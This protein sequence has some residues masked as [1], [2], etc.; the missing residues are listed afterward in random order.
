[1]TTH[2]VMKRRSG[3]TNSPSREF[4]LELDNLRLEQENRALKDIVQQNMEALKESS[5]L[6]LKQKPNR[7]QISSERKLYVAGSQHFKCAGDPSFCPMW[8]LNGGSFDISGFEIDHVEPWHKSYRND[9]A[10]L[11]ALCH[12]CHA[13]KTRLER[14]QELEMTEVCE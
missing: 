12:S 1:M 13:L 9:R 11:Q 14:L 10:I 5:T 8:K 7:P 4:Q 3:K 6:L 2:A